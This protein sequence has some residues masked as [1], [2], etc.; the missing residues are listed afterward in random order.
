MADRIITDSHFQLDGYTKIARG[1]R[2]IIDA[3]KNINGG[4]HVR[5]LRG[6]FEKRGIRPVHGP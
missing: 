4:R 1:A 6:V 5:K 2:A 3:D